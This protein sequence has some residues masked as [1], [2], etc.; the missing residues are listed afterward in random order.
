MGSWATSSS[1]LSHHIMSI[2]VGL[3]GN[4][5]PYWDLITTY[6]DLVHT[7]SSAAGALFRVF[8][9]RALTNPTFLACR[10]I[11]EKSKIDLSLTFQIC[12]VKQT[13]KQAPDMTN[14]GAIFYSHLELVSVTEV[15]GDTNCCTRKM[16]ML[17]SSALQLNAFCGVVSML[18]SS[19]Q[20][21]LLCSEWFI[22]GQQQLVL[23]ECGCC[24]CCAAALCRNR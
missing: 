24:P 11:W 16:S 19:A 6:P 9:K 13:F 17:C 7:G 18:C 8:T 2:D 21:F 22:E 5:R 20:C 12:G 1:G 14:I 15:A 23:F 10:S 4:R 3:L